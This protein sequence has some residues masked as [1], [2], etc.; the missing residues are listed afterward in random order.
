MSLRVKKWHFHVYPNTDGH[1][2]HVPPRQTQQAL[3]RLMVDNACTSNVLQ[4]D[5]DASS[6]FPRG[7]EG[8]IAQLFISP[9]PC[10]EI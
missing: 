3:S 4:R 7:A 10:R 5:R 9:N 6:H 2:T 8:P 1:L